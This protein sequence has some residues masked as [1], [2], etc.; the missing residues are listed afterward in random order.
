M[1][2]LCHA[3]VALV[4]YFQYIFTVLLLSHLGQGVALHLNNFESQPLT[5]FP[6]VICACS[7]DIEIGQ[8]V[9]EM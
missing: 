3:G 7:N 1:G 8:V 6:Q 5:P 9:L 4:Q 2:V